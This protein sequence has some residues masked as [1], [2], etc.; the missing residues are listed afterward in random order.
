MEIK[1]WKIPNK[2]KEILYLS[3]IISENM[4]FVSQIQCLHLSKKLLILKS[5]LKM[6]MNKM[7]IVNLK[8]IYLINQVVNL[9][10]MFENMRKT[11]DKIEDQLDGLYK[12]LQYYKTRN[13]RNQATVQST[14]SRIYYFSIFEVLLMVGMAFLQITIVQLFFRGSRKQLV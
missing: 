13:N 7:V 8:L 11:V 14:E 1:L 10:L 4:N 2:D 6:I 5:N 9:R 12:A 3:S